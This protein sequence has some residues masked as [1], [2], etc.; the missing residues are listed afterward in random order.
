MLNQ[1][2]P[3]KVIDSD[4]SSLLV[5]SIFYTLQ[6]EGPFS[7]RAA[8]FV[9]L[10]GCNLQCPGCDTEYSQ[11]AHMRNIHGLLDE[12]ADILYANSKAK[13]IVVITGG[14][15][16]RQNIAM[17]ANTL[18]AMGH[19]VQIETNGTLPASKG[20]HDKAVIVCSPK[21]G[22]VNP[23][24]WPR[25]SAYKF[26][27]SSS[28]MMLDGLPSKALGHSARPHLARPHAT[29][30]GPVYLQPMDE[31]DLDLNVANMQAVVASCMTFGYLLCLQTHK[32][33][34]VE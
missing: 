21:T 9:R 22:S 32:I 17:F 14:E 10:G 1:Q 34:G 26:V 18:I 33:V 4:G 29:F 16:F 27:A 19:T 2:I 12:L 5:H 20:L 24:L 23:K 6:G 15:P 8:V 31:H 7:G 11:G 28:D 25:I 3:V 30:T 13:P